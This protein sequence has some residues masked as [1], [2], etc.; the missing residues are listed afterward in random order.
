MTGSDDEG[1]ALEDS[2]L[3]EPTIYT[4]DEVAAEAGVTIDQARRLWRALGFPEHGGARAFTG[5]DAEALSTIV[6][7]V[8]GGL[9]DFDLAVT[10]TRA[11]GTTLARLADWEV[12][13]LAPRIDALADS[14][15]RATTAPATATGRS[16]GWTT[17]P[18]CS[19]SSASRSRSC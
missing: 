9:I 2:I 7:A 13:A 12:A 17:P 16:G 5:S 15:P 19:P 1:P 6:D 14:H 18:G 8:D 4:A 10:L 11:V 3:G